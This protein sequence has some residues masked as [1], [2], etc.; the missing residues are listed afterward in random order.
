MFCLVSVIAGLS[1]FYIVWYAKGS[2]VRTGCD[3]PDH[4]QDADQPHVPSEHVD[5]LGEGLVVLAALVVVAE[6]ENEHCW[7]NLLQR[8]KFL[9]APFVPLIRNSLLCKIGY[10]LHKMVLSPRLCHL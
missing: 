1:V 2:Y 3:R 8:E 6:S 5:R 10:A 7:F 4:V 9:A